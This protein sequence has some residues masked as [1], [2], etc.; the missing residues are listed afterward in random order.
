MKVGFVDAEGQG[1]KN[2]TYDA[3]LVCPILLVSKCVIFNWKG[4]LQKDHLLETLGIMTKAAKNVAV[5]KSKEE[6]GRPAAG[7]KGNGAG[8]GAGGA[9]GTAKLDEAIATT[10]KSSVPIFS[11][12]HIVFR[13]WQAADS[14]PEA[15]H[16]MIFGL[17]G[18]PEAGARDRIRKEVMESF[19]SVSP[20]MG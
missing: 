16:R 14:D 7:A 3:T 19:A 8:S 4:E 20:S 2:I 12:L 17:E 6:A 13:D 18:S 1:D 11:H 15:V 9:S 5:D 10:Q